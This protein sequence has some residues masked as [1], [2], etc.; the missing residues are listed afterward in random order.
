MIKNIALLLAGIC[1][2][3][4]SLAQ[5]KN[6]DRIAGRVGNSIILNSELDILYSQEKENKPYLEHFTKCD[7]FYEMMVQRILVAQ[8]ARDSVIVPESEIEAKIQERLA[9][10]IERAGGVEALERKS[11]KTVYQIKEENRPFFENL[12]TAQQMQAKIVE[13]VKV[14][15][16]EVEEYYKTLNPDSLPPIPATVEIGQIIF[17]PKAS[18]EMENY[19]K[20]KLEGIRKDIVEG[21]KS[22]SLMASLYGMDGTKDNGGELLLEKDKMDPIFVSAAM[23]LQPGEIT[24]VFRGKFGYH[25]VQMIAKTSNTTAKVRHIIIIPEFT[26]ADFEKIKVKADSVLQLLKTDKTTFEKAVRDYS[27]DPNASMTAGMMMSAQTNSSNLQM[28]ELDPYTATNIQNLEESEYSEP[29]FYADPYTQQR[30]IRIILLKDKVDPHLLNLKDDY[31]LIKQQALS[32]KQS[33]YLMNYINK[34]LPDFYI[35]VDKDFQSCE[36]LKPWMV[37]NHY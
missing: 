23:R 26:S 34:I 5:D 4:V 10:F 8:A 18:E 27:D 32:L 31:A 7:A 30:S 16:Y 20:E 21:G 33:E 12:L 15:P 2:A 11:G 9:Y 29:H 25:I 37:Y 28:D 35:K 1:S 19:A 36:R 24:P 13:N 3:F 22:F 6:L 14:T 17:M